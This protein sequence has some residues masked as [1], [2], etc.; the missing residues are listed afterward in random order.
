MLSVCLDRCITATIT[1]TH[2]KYSASVAARRP[3]DLSSF[4]I[5]VPSPA[6]HRSRPLVPLRSDRDG[7]KLF[8]SAASS[9]ERSRHQCRLHSSPST[10]VRCAHARAL[11]VARSLARAH[12][13]A[14]TRMPM[15]SR[16]AYIGPTTDRRE[17]ACLTTNRSQVCVF[18]AR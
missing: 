13:R 17:H 16:V 3:L 2:R 18:A 12:A 11:L 15:M 9:V 14:A 5:V 1:S 10:A 8:G 6:R 7:E 4:N